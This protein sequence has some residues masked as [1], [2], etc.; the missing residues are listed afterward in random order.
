MFAEFHTYRGNLLWVGVVLLR[1]Y[2]ST[3]SIQR[4]TRTPP[5]FL[6][7]H[8]RYADAQ[9]IAIESR[10]YPWHAKSVTQMH[11]T[12]QSNYRD[13]AERIRI[14]GDDRGQSS[15]YLGIGHCIV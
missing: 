8:E 10:I 7:R 9:H 5:Q 3:Y 6:V 4:Y 15:S 1:V 11:S 13:R 12:Q 2:E 14:H